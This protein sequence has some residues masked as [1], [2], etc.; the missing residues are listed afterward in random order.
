M[1]NIELDELVYTYPDY[2]TENIQTLLSS[3]EEFREIA[4]RIS[5]P[6]PQRGQLYR[7]QKFIKRLLTQYDSQ[8]LIHETGSGKFCSAMSVT[9]HFKI[10]AGALEEI[11][12]ST[13]A[14]DTA[15]LSTLNPPYKRAVILVKGQTLIDEAKFQLLC[16]CTNGDYIT[17]QIIKSKTEAARKGNVTRS[18]S[19]Y[20]T[21]TTYGTFAK[22]LLK[23]NDAQL[24]NEFDNTI[25][26]I[27]EVHNINDDKTGGILRIDP[28]TGNSYYVRMEKDKKTKLE[29]EVIIESRLIY[30]QLWRT[31]HTV[32]PRKVLEMSATPMINDTSEL[33]SRLNLILPADRQMPANINYRTVTLETLEPYFRGLISYVRALD[34]GAI[35]VYQGEVI[36][37]VY[38]IDEDIEEGQEELQNTQ[39]LKRIRENAKKKERNV[40]DNLED[41]LDENNPQ[42][43]NPQG[44]RAQMVVYATEMSEKQ[45]EIY[46]LAVEDP[47]ALRPE[48]L[49][50]A[51]FNDLERQVANFIFPDDSTGSVGYKKYVEEN[52]NIFTATE[53]LYEWISDPDSLRQLSAKFYEIVRLSK[54]EPGNCWCYSDFIRGSGA[55]VLGLCFEAQEFERFSEA[56]SVFSSTGSG[57]LAPIC[58]AKSLDDSDV[59]KDRFIRIPKKL[60]YALLTSETSGP[61]AAALLETFNSYENRHGEYIKAIIGSPVTRDGLNLANVLQIHLTGPGWNQASSY[62]AESRAIRSTSHVDL[63]EEERERLRKEGASAEKIEN[64]NVIIRVYRHAATDEQGTSIDM[65]MYSLSEIKDR[66][67]KRIIRMMKQVATDCQ[68]NYTRNV[69]PRD[70]DYS[71]TCDY[72]ICAY[73]CVSPAPTSVDL[74]SY[75]VLYSGEVI[76]AVKSDIIDIFRL[77]FTISYLD[78]YNELITYRRKFVDLAIFDLIE[79]KTPIFDRYGYISY[80]REDRGILFLNRDYPLNTIEK[81]GAVSLSEYTSTLLGISTLTLNEYNGYLQRGLKENILDVLKNVDPEDFASRIE[82]LT[83]EN[84]QLLLETAMSSYYLSNIKTELIERVINHFRNFI[85]IMF[86]PLE[87]LKISLTAL[88]NRGKGRGRKPREGSKFKLS[89]ASEKEVEDTFSLKP[90]KGTDI[91]YFHNLLTSV[92]ALTAYAMT[93]KSRKTEGQIRLLKPSENI[94]WREANEYEN[95]IYNAY[96]KTKIEE[97]VV[98]L[99]DNLIYGTIASDEKFRIVDKTTED[100]SLSSDDDRKKKRGLVCT[101]WKKPALIELIWKLR[102]NPFKITIDYTRE[103]LI[104]L[105]VAQKIGNVEEISEY[106]DERL[107]LYYAWLSSNSSRDRMCEKLREYFEENNLLLNQT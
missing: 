62:Q 59:K 64:A 38:T 71:A 102:Y 84:R 41:N 21:I 61:E 88:N 52:G 22:E 32:Y 74:T 106:S 47:K 26:I 24:R 101:T 76:E 27:D 83:L 23:L 67:I 45:A 25:F 34:T 60:R 56:S 16:K 105:I 8:F 44:I 40:E 39:R 96:I 33:P 7:H 98:N 6:P 55:I 77:I 100:I 92:V 51:A 14:S 79:N 65:Q 4:G 31:F 91:I 87:G 30:D 97:I 107:R 75:D 1:E 12:N 18:L 48:S 82:A 37:A 73:K 95:P 2:N 5:E 103:Q 15:T 90:K 35:P 99:G 63:I 58:A 104:D 10:L 13:S 68:I 72:D 46:Q 3:K 43:I 53:E 20:Y 54:E 80:L 11:R 42:G 85:F 69:R 50:P 49:N 57:S 19:R 70:I 36:D 93:A 78:L 86:E 28:A 9:E 17:D 66:E 29:K 89:E 81:E 94:G